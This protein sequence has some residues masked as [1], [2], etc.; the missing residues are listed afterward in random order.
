MA[1]WEYGPKWNWQTAKT[2]LRLATLA[3]R[4]RLKIVNSEEARAR[5]GYKYLCLTI[6]KMPVSKDHDYDNLST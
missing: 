4:G 6:S 3:G 5:G 1:W 2:F